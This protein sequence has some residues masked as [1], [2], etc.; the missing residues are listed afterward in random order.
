MRTGQ[1]STP[2]HSQWQRA[3]A[4]VAVASMRSCFSCWEH[5]PFAS[6]ISATKRCECAEQRRAPRRAE[7]GTRIPARGRRPGA[8]VPL[9]DIAECRFADLV[10][11]GVHIAERRSKL[12]VTSRDQRCPERCDCT[13]TADYRSLAVYHHLVAGERIGVTGNIG[14]AAA[15]G[16]VR[17]LRDG[18]PR[19][20][21]W[22]GERLAHAAAGCTLTRARLVP[23]HLAR[24]RTAAAYELGAAAGERVGTRGRK[25]HMR[26]AVA[27]AV[28]RA[29]V[30]G[31]RRNGDAKRHGI[32][33]RGLHRIT[34]GGGPAVFRA[35][36]ADRHDADLVDGIVS[37]L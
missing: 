17:R 23:H 2:R 8:V 16:A 5:W 25:I 32:L 28:A 21:L 7:P 20:P 9:R 26:L 19:L 27:L 29:A 35:S 13:G 14:H 1:L 12:L 33:E 11:R 6:A 30:T 34:G 31:S 3:A 22:Q 18:T 10:E 37:C 36:P 4:G 15:G 24:D